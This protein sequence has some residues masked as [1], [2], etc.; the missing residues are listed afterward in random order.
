MRNNNALVSVIVTTYNRELKILKRAIN[1]ILC[2][3]YKNIEVIVV[4]DCPENVSLNNSISNYFDSIKETRISYIVHTHNMGACKARNTGI[5]HSHGQFIAF[6]DDDDEWEKDK[7][8]KQLALFTDDDIGVIYCFFNNIC[9]DGSVEKIKPCEESGNLFE[10][11][12]KG[13]CV[14]GTSMPLIRADVFK[15][16]GLFDEKLLSSQDHD[17]WLRIASEFEFVCCKEYLV[18]RFMQNESITYNIEKQY[19]GFNRFIKKHYKYYKK[20]PDALNYVLNQKAKR[21]MADGHF[22]KAREIYVKAFLIKPFSVSNVTEPL[23]G[24]FLFLFQKK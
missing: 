10:M 8:E 9:T 21:W 22:A 19:Q 24:F 15:K 20:R 6:L 12:L 1:S 13:N 23:K 2:Q 18:N 5:I 4:N 3:T 16:V 7:I 11:L 14:G 17:L